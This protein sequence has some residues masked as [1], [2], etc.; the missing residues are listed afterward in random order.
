MNVVM[1]GDDRFVEV[2]GTAERG[3]FDRAAL[4]AMVDL[5]SVGISELTMH[6]QKALGVPE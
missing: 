5:A 2:Q 4:D 3:V 6:Q 1:T